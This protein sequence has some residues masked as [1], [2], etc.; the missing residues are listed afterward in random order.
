MW[1]S[2]H[3]VSAASLLDLFTVHYSLRGTNRRALEE[4]AVGHWWDWIIEVEDGDAAVEVDGGDT[5]K[6]TLQNVLVFASG[7]SAIP[8]FGL[9]E[10]PKITFLHENINGNR[11]IFTEAN[12]CTITLNLPIGFCHYMTSGVIQS[13]TFGVAKNPVLPTLIT[14]A[15]WLIA[16]LLDCCCFFVIFFVKH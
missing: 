5:I 2:P 12:T 1:W 8:V 10:N 16:P 4:V 15:M 13:P 14:L 6:I 3:L 11:R 7:V 9:K